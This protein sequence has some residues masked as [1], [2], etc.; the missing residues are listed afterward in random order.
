M[1]SEQQWEYIGICEECGAPC[2]VMDGR[3]KSTSNTNCL[4]WVK[5]YEGE[6]EENENFKKN[7]ILH[8]E[9][10]ESIKSSSL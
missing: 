7:K 5:G 8:N 3:F 9:Q 2:Y 4:C 1:W 10:L 6:E